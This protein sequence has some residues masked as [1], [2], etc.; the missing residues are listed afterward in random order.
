M[1]TG[2]GDYEWDLENFI[3]IYTHYREFDNTGLL[4]LRWQEN[5]EGLG[6]VRICRTC[7]WQYGRYNCTY[8]KYRQN[9]AGVLS[10]F[11]QLLPYAASGIPRLPLIV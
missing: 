1:T 2:S 11:A 5:V 4:A 3:D 7:A 8:V 6:A 10:Q 9:C